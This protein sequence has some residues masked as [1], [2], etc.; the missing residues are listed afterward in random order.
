[1]RVY[2]PIRSA[3]FLLASVGVIAQALSAYWD[4]YSHRVF[5]I[6]FDPWWNPAHLTL[7]GGA[8]IVIAGLWVGFRQNPQKSPFTLGFKVAWIGAAM[9]VVAGVWNEIWHV[10]YLTEPIISPPHA[11]LVLGMITVIFGMLS[12]MTS[13]YTLIISQT[14]SRRFTLPIL[15]TLVMMFASIWLVASG[16][17]IYL[18]GILTTQTL[19]MIIVGVLSAI[20]PLVMI[21]ALKTFQKMGSVIAIGLVFSLINWIFLVGYVGEEPYIPYGIITALVIEPLYRVTKAR[22]HDE[23]GYCR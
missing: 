3:G 20:A 13:Y 6:D 19:R 10:I 16:S 11:L 12:G 4:V 2:A 23:G 21:P 1:M 8:L 5:F 22:N 7:Q 14:S 17:V 18:A 15:S 9:E